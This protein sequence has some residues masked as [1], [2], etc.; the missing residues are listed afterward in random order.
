VSSQSSLGVL[1]HFC[2]PAGGRVAVLLRGWLS[3]CL[4]ELGISPVRSEYCVPLIDFDFCLCCVWIVAGTYPGH[5]LELPDQKAQ[6][7][8]VPIPLPR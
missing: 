1:V 3:L 6:G 2:A 7:F 4:R 5:T 8:L